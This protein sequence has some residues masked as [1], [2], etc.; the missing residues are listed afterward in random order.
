MRKIV[1]LFLTFLTGYMAG[2]F[3]SAPLMALAGMEAVFFMAA[4]FQCRY[5]RRHLSA[6]ALRHGDAMEKSAWLVCRMKIKNTGKLSVSRFR[7]KLWYGYLRGINFPAGFA[8]TQAASQKVHNRFSTLKG[9][10][11]VKRE[12]K[13]KMTNFRSKHIDGSCGRGESTVQFEVSGKHCG[14]MTLRMVRLCAYDYL[15]LFSSSKKMDEAVEVAVYPQEKALDLELHSFGEGAEGPAQEQVSGCGGD[16]DHEV[17]QLREYQS[18]DS[19][20]YIHWNQTART[21]QL[22]VKEYEREADRCIRLYLDM[23]GMEKAEDEEADAY[24]ELLSALVLG[25]LKQARS[26]H[27]SWHDAAGRT[28]DMEVSGT[29]QCRSLLLCLYRRNLPEAVSVLQMAGEQENGKD[30]DGLKLDMRLGLYRDNVLLYQFS[31][32]NIAEQITDGKYIL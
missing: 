3:R 22:W 32:E 28:A 5:L 23:D 15:A 13:Q 9:H 4:F 29:E 7:V 14:I 24:Y 2:V 1:F 31:A 20:R 27:V 17:R 16:A 11:A 30:G 8:G 26:V 19:S 25:L 21:G 10:M 12:N 18:G 6:E